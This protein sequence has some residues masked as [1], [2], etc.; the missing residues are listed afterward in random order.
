[1]KNDD[2]DLLQQLVRYGGNQAFELVPLALKKV[3]EEQQWQN[4][5]DRAG[6]RFLSFEAFVRHPLWQG[7]ETTIDDLRVFCR[8]QPEV[9]RLILEAMEP[10]RTDGG[11]RRSAEFQSNNITLKR[12]T[13]AIYT[14]K[15]LKRDHPSLFH[16]VLSGVMSANAAAIEA[17]IRKKPLLRCPKCGHEWQKETKN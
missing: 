8:K 7:L 14:L 2:I 6:D 12:G 9:Q 15:R 3:I 1:M 10:G 17:G 11:D 13:S 5:V 4:Q 16:Q